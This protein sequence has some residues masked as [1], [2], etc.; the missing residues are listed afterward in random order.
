MKRE[1]E[2]LAWLNDEDGRMRKGPRDVI[3][4]RPYFLFLPETTVRA[5]S[6]K[7]K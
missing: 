7:T 5:R 6:V 4:Q 2:S 3:Y 1:F